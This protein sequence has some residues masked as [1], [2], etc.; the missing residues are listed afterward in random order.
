MGQ[1]LLQRKSRLCLAIR[2]LNG[3]K[4]AHQE[5][6]C[7]V[8]DECTW[9]CSLIRRVARASLRL[10]NTKKEETNSAWDS[11]GPFAV[12][13]GSETLAKPSVGAGLGHFR[14][15]KSVP[16]SPQTISG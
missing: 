7:C 3:S 5:F 6:G 12:F 9:T 11:L 2:L 16:L 14:G 10:S 8:V 4:H 13:D 1:R 15:L